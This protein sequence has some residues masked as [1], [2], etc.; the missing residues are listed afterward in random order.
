[1][2]KYLGIIIPIVVSVVSSVF[3]FTYFAGRNLERINIFEDMQ[4]AHEDKLKELSER[5]AKLEGKN[6][7]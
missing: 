7:Q 3:A 6:E 5:V 2:D 1:M 4:G